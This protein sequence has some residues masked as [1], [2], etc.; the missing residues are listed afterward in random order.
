MG[1][2]IFIATDWD[3]VIWYSEHPGPDGGGPAVLG[4]CTA[5]TRGFRAGCDST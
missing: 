1:A 5:R 2:A 3:S 4:V